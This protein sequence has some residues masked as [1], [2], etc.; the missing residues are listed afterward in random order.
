MEI[1]ASTPDI[2]GNLDQNVTPATD[3]NTDLIQIS[4]AR[5]VRGNLS[6]VID[7]ATLQSWANPDSTPEII[8]EA[9]AKLIAAQ[10]YFNEISKTTPIIDP[11][12]LAQKLYD[13]GMAIL[14]GVI[15]GTIVIENIITTSSE[16]MSVLDFHP[17]DA[18]DRAFTMGMNI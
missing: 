13:Q 11:D 16:S 9:A 7:N 14:N 4:V 18:T 6:T 10:H 15:G 8:R 2:N 12:S 17:S 1:L 5:I 3:D